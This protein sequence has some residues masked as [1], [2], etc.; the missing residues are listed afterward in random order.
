MPQ[1]GQL[2]LRLA[3]ATVT[4]VD[5]LRIASAE[6]EAKLHQFRADYATALTHAGEMEKQIQALR[7][8]AA[9][10]TAGLQDST[11]AAQG[12][13]A[14]LHAALREQRAAGGAGRVVAAG[15]E[16]G[17]GAGRLQARGARGRNHLC[18]ALSRLA[19]RPGTAA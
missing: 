7:A 16:L 15:A 9:H 4:S 13:L 18:V 6:T 2:T 3:N 14:A 12:E 19:R 10:H 5:A 11:L 8:D 1:G 17:R